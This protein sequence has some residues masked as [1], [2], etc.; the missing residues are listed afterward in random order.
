MTL[1]M[2]ATLRTELVRIHIELY[3][4]GNETSKEDRLSVMRTDGTCHPAPYQFVYLRVRIANLSR[5][6][7]LRH[8]HFDRFG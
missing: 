5:K 1:P 8:F 2:L 4:R 3:R 6:P 7:Y